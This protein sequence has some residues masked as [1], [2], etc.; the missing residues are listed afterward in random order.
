[1]NRRGMKQQVVFYSNKICNRERL[2]KTLYFIASNYSEV[3]IE[4][5]EEEFLKKFRVG[6]IDEKL[7]EQFNESL[8]EM[9]ELTDS[10]IKCAIDLPQSEE[11]EAMIQE[12]AL[13][14]KYNLQE[15]LD[16]FTE[17]AREV[18]LTL[19][20]YGIYYALQKTILD[21][22]ERFH[23]AIKPFIEFRMLHQS[24]GNNKESIYDLI[25]Q[26]P[27]CKLIWYRV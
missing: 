19:D 11:K 20:Y 27:C 8:Q 18:M 1:M 25:K 15:R 16:K 21:A 12:L 5:S 9:E 14:L 13:D 6:C 17:A 26:C 10:Y 24:K 4:I 3:K 23:S 22:D 7:K 2:A